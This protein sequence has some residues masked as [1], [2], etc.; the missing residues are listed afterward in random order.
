MGFLQL[1]P[2][3]IEW[4]PSSAVG[5]IDEAVEG[6]C[7]GRIR[8][9]GTHWFARS[10][11]ADLGLTFVV[12]QPVQILGRQGNTLLILPSSEQLLGA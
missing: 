9:G 3:P 1:P 11:T 2:P 10:Y 4:F 5:V 8:Y 12:G 7:P 6:D